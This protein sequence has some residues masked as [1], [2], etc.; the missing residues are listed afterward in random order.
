MDLFANL[1]PALVFQALADASPL[2]RDSA[3]IMRNYAS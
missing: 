2:K 1:R 3:A